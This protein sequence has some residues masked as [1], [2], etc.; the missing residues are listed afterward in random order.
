R[1][2]DRAGRCDDGPSA[3]SGTVRSTT[4][5]SVEVSSTV[6]SSALAAGRCV[7]GPAAGVPMSRPVVPLPRRQPAPMAARQ[8]AETAKVTASTPNATAGDVAV[9]SSPAT[10]G[11]TSPAA[12]VAVLCSALPA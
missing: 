12:N 8:A 10:P 7:A 9:T 6:T 2:V 5:A 3:P 11:P 1:N 4:A